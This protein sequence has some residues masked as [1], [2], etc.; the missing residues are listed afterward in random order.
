[1]VTNHRLNLPDPRLLSTLGK[2]FVLTLLGLKKIF[3]AFCTL[4][5]SGLFCFV[6]FFF[7]NICFFI[8]LV[9][10]EAFF[11]PFMFIVVMLLYDVIGLLDK[12]YHMQL[13]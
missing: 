9:A 4:L 13:S 2:K 3:L 1:M 6:F 10:I 8:M 5:I 11:F 7:T 12:Y